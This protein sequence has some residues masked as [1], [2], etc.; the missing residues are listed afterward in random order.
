M[1]L[2]AGLKSLCR[3][4]GDKQDIDVDFTS[5]DIPRSVRS[6]VGLCLFRIT[7]EGLQNLKKY[8]GIKKAQL[9]V[10]HVGNRLVLSL[11]DEGKGFDASMLEKPGLGILSMRAR[12]RVLGGEFEIHSKP[13]KGTRIDVWV[14]RTSHKSVKCLSLPDST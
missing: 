2:V 5:E 10:C 6:D 14:P 3:E 11:C 9:S 1:G 13:G 4:F 12:A 8:S 7:Q